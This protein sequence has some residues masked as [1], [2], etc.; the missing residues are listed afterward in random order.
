MIPSKHFNLSQ[1]EFAFIRETLTHIL[2]LEHKIMS[3]IS[4]FAAKMN[5]F[6]A[7]QDT[8]M[9]DLQGDVDNLVAQIAALN[10]S[11][12]TITAEDQALLDGIVAR[13]SSVSDKLDS[14]DALTPPTVP[15]TV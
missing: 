11:S 12:G 15:P 1:Q 8:A 5:T 4:D 13:A 10:A 9:A 2:N 7:R 14:L 3:A 6:T